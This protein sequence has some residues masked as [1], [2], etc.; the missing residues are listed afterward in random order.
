MRAHSFVVLLAISLY[1]C[2]RA[3]PKWTDCYRVLNVPYKRNPT[4]PDTFD[5]LLERDG[6]VRGQYTILSQQ[7]KVKDSDTEQEKQEKEAMQKMLD[8]AFDTIR[9]KKMQKSYASDPKCG[10][11]DAAVHKVRNKKGLI[12]CPESVTVE[13]LVQLDGSPLTCARENNLHQTEIRGYC[14]F[15]PWERFQAGLSPPRLSSGC[16][17]FLSK[18]LFGVPIPP[19]N[20]EKVKIG[21]KE[22]CQ[23]TKKCQTDV[24][25]CPKKGKKLDRRYIKNRPFTCS[26]RDRQDLQ[27]LCKC[28]DCKTKKDCPKYTGKQTI[29]P[30]WDYINKRCSYTKTCSGQA[31]NVQPSAMVNSAGLSAVMVVTLFLFILIFG[32]GCMALIGCVAGLIF[33]NAVLTLKDK[34]SSIHAQCQRVS[35]V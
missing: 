18:S 9:T 32:A 29:E 35:D 30:Q 16:P 10:D 12:K 11:P 23:Y 25:Q 27:W 31:S 24:Q 28:Q 19:G 17:K 7:N 15:V 4:K 21:G 13:S 14:K 26:R 2:V 34:T 33:G 20:I 3:E 5:V 6:A 8:F 1:V 22:L